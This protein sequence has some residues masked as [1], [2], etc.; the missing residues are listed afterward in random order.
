MGLRLRR[1]T[2]TQRQSIIFAE[3]ELIYTTDTL[4]IYVGDGSTLGGIKVTDSGASS[5][6]S[7]TQ[8]LN[9]NSFNISGTGNISATNIS[10]NGSGL[11][12][13]NAGNLS[14]GSVPDARISSTSVTQHQAN[15]TGLGT[16]TSGS[17]GSGFGNID[18]GNNVFTGDGSGLFNLPS[19]GI[20]PGDDYNINIV[21][22]DST[23]IIDV[24]TNTITGQILL[25]GDLNMDTFTIY[26][27]GDVATSGD[28]Y[29]TNAIITNVTASGAVSGSIF[30]GDGSGLTNL[31]I[32]PIIEGN[33]YSIN[34]VGLDSTIIVDATNNTFNGSL[35]GSVVGDVVGSVFADNSGL[36][37]DGNNSNIFANNVNTNSIISDPGLAI[38]ANNLTVTANTASVINTFTLE[39]EDEKVNIKLSRTSS[40]D[41]TGVP[42]EY[43]SIF[44]QRNDS[45]GEQVT[46][47]ITGYTTGMYFSVADNSLSFPESNAVAIT[48]LGRMGIGT[49][50]PSAKLDVRGNAV[51]SGDVSAAAFKGS[52]MSDDST[53]IIDGISGNITAPGFVQFGSFTKAERDGLP[54]SNGL[55]VYNT[56]SNRFQGYQNGAWIN[57]DDG[58]LDP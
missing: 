26:G 25:T 46:S 55:V 41:L 29:A 37:I 5:P 50:S 56:T 39:S 24:T 12:S 42:L 54:A 10:G 16:V 23:R 49:F 44:F 14:S 15:I 30:Y 45:N 43:G 52:I 19:G 13:L 20:T 6:A 28:L 51:F 48:S 40:S 2:N 58:T 7:L 32:A 17:I 47:L 3:G 4:E 8:N 34:I 36:I 57:I 1:G 38:S 11:F 22:D 53:T 9:L 21:G 31:P 35:I 18:I 33:N 27:D